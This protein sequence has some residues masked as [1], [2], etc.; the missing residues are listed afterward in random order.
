MLEFILLDN[1]RT[2]CRET[3]SQKMCLFSMPTLSK[4]VVYTETKVN[5]FTTNMFI[6]VS[7]IPQVKNK[8]DHI[9][10]NY[11]L[12][13]LYLLWMLYD[14]L[15]LLGASNIYCSFIYSGCY[16]LCFIFWVR[17]LLAFW[18]IAVTLSGWMFTYFTVWQA[19]QLLH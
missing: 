2:L 4:W 11:I 6:L 16:M 1:F 7:M 9:W 8:Q 18:W 12:L 10:V 19:V 14:L 15:H 17:L 5:K 3:K 13:Q